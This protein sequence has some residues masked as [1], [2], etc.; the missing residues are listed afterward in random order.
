MR[1]SHG[2]AE[3]LEHINVARFIAQALDDYLCSHFS[4][5]QYYGTAQL[6]ASIQDSPCYLKPSVTFAPICLSRVL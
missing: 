5:N 6:C 4:K 1:L 3:T 2:L